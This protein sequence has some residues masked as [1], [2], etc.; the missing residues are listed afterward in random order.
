MIKINVMGTHA[1]GKS[2]LCFQIANLLKI[3]KKNVKVLAEN[4]R[5]CPFPINKGA[6]LETELW[7]LHTTTLSELQAQ[8]EG[9]EAIVMDR[10]VLDGIVYF[11]ERNTPNQYYDVCKKLAYMWANK[12]YDLHVIVEPDDADDDYYIDSARD[13]D[14][15]YRKKIMELFREMGKDWDFIDSTNSVMVYSSEV[16]RSNRAIELITQKLFSIGLIDRIPE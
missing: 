12:E 5:A 7:I 9:Y 3:C 1:C 8:A 10:G 14:I 15:L 2:T 6:T 13:S 4:A 11:Q 16:F